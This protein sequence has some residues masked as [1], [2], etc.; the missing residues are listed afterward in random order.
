MQPAEHALLTA[1]ASESLWKA[2]ELLH[3]QRSERPAELARR[4]Q[5]SRQAVDRQLRRAER[6]GLV[7]AYERRRT[8]GRPLRVFG[9]T[10]EGRD[11]LL[12]EAA[13]LRTYR[14]LW[15][16]RLAGRQKDLDIQLASGAIEESEFLR[17]SKALRALAPEL[18][19]TAGLA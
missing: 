11:L 1:L 15:R 16:I 5:V 2:L 4:L 19:L 9:L 6:L 10:G 7:E 18:E 17:R 8:P 3:Q 14:E 12:T 13:V